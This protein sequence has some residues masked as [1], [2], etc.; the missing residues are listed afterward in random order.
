MVIVILG[1]LAVVAI[2]RYVDLQDEARR[3]SA[4]GTC[5]EYD[6]LINPDYYITVDT[7]ES[8]LSPTAKAQLSAS[9]K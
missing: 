7:A 5:D 2:P 9:W 4:D 6:G 8:P 3:A 1:T